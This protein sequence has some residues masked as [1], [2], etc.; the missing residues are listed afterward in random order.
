MGELVARRSR[1][2]D[3]FVP[4]Q[5]GNATTVVMSNVRKSLRAN[6]AHKL[7]STFTLK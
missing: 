6:G 3:Q 2:F 1:T 7:Y 4:A 5:I